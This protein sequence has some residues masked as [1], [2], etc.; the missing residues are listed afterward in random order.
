MG[1]S[2]MLWFPGQGVLYHMGENGSIYK[3]VYLH[4]PEAIEMG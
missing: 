1:W 2:G 4:F 3:M